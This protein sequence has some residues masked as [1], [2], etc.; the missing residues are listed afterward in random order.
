MKTNLF[1]QISAATFLSATS[2][3]PATAQ[4]MPN[5]NP[6]GKEQPT[7]ATNYY[8]PIAEK[9]FYIKAYGFYALLAPGGFR[10]QGAPATTTTVRP[11]VIF[12]TYTVTPTTQTSSSDYNSKNTFGSGLRVGG[13]M[14]LVI[15]DFINLGIDG[16]YLLGNQTTENYMLTSKTILVSKPTNATTEE[17]NYTSSS[18]EKYTSINELM[19]K[20]RIFN[21]IPNITFKAVSKPEYYIYNRLGLVIGIP[22]QLSYS[23]TEITTT[24]R[25]LYPGINDYKTTKRTYDLEKGMGL[26]YQAALGIQFRIS[27]SLRG[28]TELVASNQQVKTDKST[29]TDAQYKQS[30]PGSTDPNNN[31]FQKEELKEDDKVK[32]GLNWTMPVHSVGLSVGLSL[33]F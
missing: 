2:L 25:P 17:A 12:G 4:T 9:K 8:Q 20:C 3:L 26:G 29:L 31:Q 27:E 7:S 5:P 32:T 33:R 18:F 16:E 30:S 14:G 10:G 24:P 21:I 15:N 28:F 22:G 1:L 13:G 19:Y 11:P 23:T 6:P